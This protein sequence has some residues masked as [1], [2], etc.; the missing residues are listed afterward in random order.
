MCVQVSFCKKVLIVYPKLHCVLPDS[1][2]MYSD[3]EV[4]TNDL[5]LVI[6]SIMLLRKLLECK[7]I[8]E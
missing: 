1:Q 4:K 5:C 8:S 2:D 3:M 6:I 7:S